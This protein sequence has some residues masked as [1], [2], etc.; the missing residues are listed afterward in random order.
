M[1]DLPRSLVTVGAGQTAVAAVRLLRRRGFHGRVTV[2]S[3]ELHAPYQR[4]PLSKEFLRGETEPEDLTLLDEA[5]CAGNDVELRLGVR[6]EF[7]AAGV[8][9][10][11]DGSELTSDAILLA[12]GVSAR[13]LPGVGGDRVVYLRT[14]DDAARLR[15]MLSAAERI[16]V[17]GGGLIGSEVASAARESGIAVTVLEAGALPLLSQ[18][19]PEMAGFY[20]GLHRQYGVDLRCGQEIGAVDET[21]GGVVVRTAAGDVEADLVV[22]AVGA[23][24]N[25]EIARVSGIPV[26]PVRGGIVVD[27]GCRTAVP[28]VF[29]AGDVASRAVGDGFVRVEHVDNATTQ[30]TAVAKALIGKPV[31]PADEVP[32]FWSDQYELG[33]QF[34]GRPRPG[35]EIV[36]RGSVDDRDFTAFYLADGCVHAAFAVD[37]GGDVPAAKQLIA[38]G[39]PVS[40]A[41]LADEDTDLFDLLDTISA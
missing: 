41:A 32:W 10:L 11:S 8:V 1:S 6:A 18:L 33:L 35:A 7:V 14:L 25:D 26:D 22:V 30:G 15:G 39:L 36:V 29:A 16:A 38:S 40:P 12:T 9:R 37:R 13:R 17:V 19:G 21:A 27:D 24:A 23:V 34:V 28:G 3:D 2:L 5:W 4:P 31:G 20:A